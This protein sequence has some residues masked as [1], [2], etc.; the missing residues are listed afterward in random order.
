MA[1]ILCGLRRRAYAQP[2]ADSYAAYAFFGD[3]TARLTLVGTGT[4]RPTR[5]LTAVPLY[6]DLHAGKR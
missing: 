4:S 1:E 3:L 2:D 6:A 5:R